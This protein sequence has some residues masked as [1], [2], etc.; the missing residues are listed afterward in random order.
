MIQFVWPWAF[1]L[2]PL[3][4]LIHRFFPPALASEEAALWVP[5]LSPFSDA[6]HTSGSKKWPWYIFIPLILCWC[7]LITATAR[8]QWLG[9]PFELPVSG[10]DLVLAV[11]LSGSMQT[12]DFEVRGRKV[13]RLTALKVVATEFIRRRK[14]DRLG[15]ILFGKKS[16]R[17]K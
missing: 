10:R 11:D 17:Y 1:A 14:G 7:S 5:S 2:L 12:E 15:L 4:Y 9:D 8:P 3:P 16:G 6:S 13:D